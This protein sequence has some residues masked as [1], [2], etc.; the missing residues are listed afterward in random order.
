MRGL[1]KNDLIACGIETVHATN[2]STH[3][4]TGGGGRKKKRLVQGSSQKK[5]KEG[6]GG[7]VVQSTF[8]GFLTTSKQF[9]RRKWG[10]P[11][12]AL[13]RSLWCNIESDCH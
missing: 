11:F 4:H 9:C 12:S 10:S 1:V 5:N 8:V 2:Y 3:T 6:G 13:A 7:E